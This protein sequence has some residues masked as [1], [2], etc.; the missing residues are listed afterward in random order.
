VK[1]HS[2]PAPVKAPP[3]KAK[4]QAP[5]P[6]ATAPTPPTQPTP[7]RGDPN[8]GEK[9]KQEARSAKIGRALLRI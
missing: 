9:R 6:V 5:A 4:K 8:I 2:K 1:K 7:P 3:A